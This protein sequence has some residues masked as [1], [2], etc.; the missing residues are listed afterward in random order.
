MEFWA[1]FFF[2]T[3]FGVIGLILIAIISLKTDVP[4]REGYVKVQQ[5]CVAGYKP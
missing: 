2:G 1:G 5:V 3:I 4:C